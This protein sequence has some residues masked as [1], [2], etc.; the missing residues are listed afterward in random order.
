MMETQTN[1]I[2]TRLETKLYLLTTL[3][4]ITMFLLV[5]LY[6]PGTEMIPGI[7]DIETVGIFAAGTA[8][9]LISMWSFYKKLKQKRL[10]KTEPT[11]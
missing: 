2:M 6:F 1:V 9:F 7:S 4:N 11:P 10:S 8:L 3:L 5:T